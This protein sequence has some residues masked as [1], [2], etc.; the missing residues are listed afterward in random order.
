ME[1][2]EVHEVSCDIAV[3]RDD[4]AVARWTGRTGRTRGTLN[5]SDIRLQRTLNQIVLE[6]ALILDVV[7]NF[8]GDIGVVQSLCEPADINLSS[9]STVARIALSVALT[10]SVALALSVALTLSITLALSIALDVTRLSTLSTV[11]LLASW[12]WRP[13]RSDD[14]TTNVVTGQIVLNFSAD[15]LPR[16]VSTI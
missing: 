1:S 8:H 12:T 14:G 9:V 3:G 7:C 13:W 16:E 2:E 11:S 4:T 6:Q 15:A 5:G 10:W